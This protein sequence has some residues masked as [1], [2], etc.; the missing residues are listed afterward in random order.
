MD[1]YIQICDYNHDMTNILDVLTKDE[2]STGYIKS[3]L[4]GSTI[5]SEDEICSNIGVL[6]QGKLKIVS[7]LDSGK[8]VIFNIIKPGMMFGNNL[9]FSN[10]SVYKGDVVSVEQS[11]VIFF[12]KDNFVSILKDNTEFLSRYL[13]M[14]SE[15]CKT[16]N[17]Q[18]KILNFAKATERLD[19]YFQINGGIIHYKSITELANKLFL[20]REATSRMI[21]SLIYEKKIKKES[22]ALIKI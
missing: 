13:N 12:S 8:E 5:F 16:L 18:I 19:Y 15:F 3:F 4:K 17:S 20:T 11:K 1:F 10:D 9:I 22:N 6:L 7:Y 21:S 2:F 14:Q